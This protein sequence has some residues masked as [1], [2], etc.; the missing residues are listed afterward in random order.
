MAKLKR[1]YNY[2]IIGLVFGLTACSLELSMQPPLR[3]TN[4]SP[5][6]KHPDFIHGERITTTAGYQITGAFGE[7]S[8]NRKSL[9]NNNWKIEGV[10]YE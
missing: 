9:N 6:R 1:I 3:S 5:P 8:E 2:V 4:A 10:F 7:I